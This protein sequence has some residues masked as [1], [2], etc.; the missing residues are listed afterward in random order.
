MKMFLRFIG[1]WLIA[2]LC[3]KVCMAQDTALLIDMKKL[4][5]MKESFSKVHHFDTTK[6]DKTIHYDYYLD[7]EG[8]LFKITRKWKGAEGRDIET[9]K[10]DTTYQSFSF[11]KEDL[12]FAEEKLLWI[13]NEDDVT[14]WGGTYYFEK[15]KLA[16]IN[17]M[18]H[19]K[20]EDDNWDAEKEVL[21][22]FKEAL[23]DVTEY[24]EAEKKNNRNVI[25]GDFDEDQ[26][27]DSFYLLRDDSGTRLAYRL[28]S[29]N[30]FGVVSH[31]LDGAADEEHISM[32]SKTNSV[33]LSQ[34]WMRYSNTIAFR[35]SKKRN[36]FIITDFNSEA[37]GNAANDGSGSLHYDLIKDSLIASY[38]YYD[39]KQDSLASLPTI[40]YQPGEGII[41]LKDFGDTVMSHLQSYEWRSFEEGKTRYLLKDLKPGINPEIVLNALQVLDLPA[42]RAVINLISVKYLPS[43]NKV[44]AVVIPEI[45]E[46]GENNTFSYDAHILL[47]DTIAKKVLYQYDEKK[48]WQSSS[49]ALS[50]ITI[51]ASPYALNKKTI[52]FGIVSAYVGRSQ[53]SPL[54][55]KLISLFIPEGTGLKKVLNN[56][57]VNEF[58]GE[59]EGKCGGEF[60]KDMS[61]INLTEDSNNG[62]VDLEIKTTTQ[63]ITGVEKK[64]K[65]DEKV[66]DEYTE[67]K[68]LTFD[69]EIYDE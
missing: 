18:G 31:Y 61:V 51:D 37:F 54:N 49:S 34:E 44:T 57:T 48:Y 15:N 53:Q 9:L 27:P 10:T 67:S 45:N 2:S 26:Q 33:I 35:Y 29:Q 11:L 22:N 40:E 56:L 60:E 50:E 62:F 69:G 36:G 41:L 25:T 1:I 23:A 12:I 14:A 55:E 32:D 8:Q 64:G 6:A 4:M 13:Y 7:D 63:K 19:G 28:S 5:D 17:T 30:Y 16:K 58:S 42:D 52:A 68:T 38:N 24:I 39:N 46:M 21:Q 3:F 65:C 43:I 20:S 66:T 59:R 47:L